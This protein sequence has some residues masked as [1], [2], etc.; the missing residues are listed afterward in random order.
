MTV[1]DVAETEVVLRRPGSVDECRPLIA[2]AKEE[3]EDIAED[4]LASGCVEG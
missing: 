2:E 3:A 4:A 1:G